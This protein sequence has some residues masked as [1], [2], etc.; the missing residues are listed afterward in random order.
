MRLSTLVG[1][2]AGSGVFRDTRAWHGATPNLSNEIRAMPSIEY[3]APARQGR[4]FLKTMP[5][6]LW[7]VLSPHAQHV[8]RYIKEDPGIWPYGAGKMSA[9]A[10]ARKRGYLED[11]GESGNVDTVRTDPRSAGTA[12]RL[13]N[14]EK[15]GGY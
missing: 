1:A 4:G 2:P 5:H 15:G 11:S 3:S 13:F 9:L 8:C 14:G 6:E 12:V 7:T 10:S